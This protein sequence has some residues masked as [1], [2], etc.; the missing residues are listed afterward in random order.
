MC[1]V[2]SGDHCQ[3]HELMISEEQL[4]VRTQAHQPITFSSDELSQDVTVTTG[5]PELTT[6]HCQPGLVAGQLQ[7]LPGNQL[8]SNQLPSGQHHLPPEY[9]VAG[10]GSDELVQ[11]G[12]QELSVDALMLSGSYMVDLCPVCNDRVSGYHYG[13]QTCESCKG[14]ISIYFCE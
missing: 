4:T 1:R 14:N 13:L 9:A 10:V 3:P 2:L 7:L 5:P 8:P 6:R 12:Q 11:S